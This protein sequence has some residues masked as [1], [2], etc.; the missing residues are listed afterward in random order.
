[1]VKDGTL[2]DDYGTRMIEV[3]NKADLL[4]GADA[5]PAW[6][7]S[8]AVSA[9]SG[10]GLDALRALLEERLAAGLEQADYDVA[11]ADGARLAWLYEHGEV[12]GRQDDDEA[13]HVRVRL[14]PAD[15]ARFER[16]KEGLV[17]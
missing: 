7:G 9:T 13:A 5:L 16:S 3:R 1:M 4:G 14:L 15:R 11:H 12:I 2:H 6:P 10:E 17:S 8:V